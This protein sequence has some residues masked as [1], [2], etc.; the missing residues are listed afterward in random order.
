[1]YICNNGAILF[2]I[3]LDSNRVSFSLSESQSTTSVL[4][5][6]Q[7]DSRSTTNTSIVLVLYFHLIDQLEELL[8][9]Y[10]YEMMMGQCRSLM[11]SDHNDI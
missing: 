8:K 5:Y 11:A 10:D 2:D 1:M 6:C 4:S 3:A 9:S 7:C